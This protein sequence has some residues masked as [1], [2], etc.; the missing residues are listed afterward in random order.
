MNSDSSK[1]VKGRCWSEWILSKSS[2]SWRNQDWTNIFFLFYLE[3][4]RSGIPY[5]CYFL[6]QFKVETLS[7]FSKNPSLSQPSHLDGYA[8]SQSVLP[9]LFKRFWKFQLLLQLNCLLTTAARPTTSRPAHLQCYSN[10]ISGKSFF[11]FLIP[12]E[13]LG[14]D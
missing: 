2:S 4:K 11:Y 8:P 12:W 1:N 10:P 14:S 9:T 13:T 7:N 5:N 6:D 3:R